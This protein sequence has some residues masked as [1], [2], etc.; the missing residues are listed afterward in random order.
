MLAIWWRCWLVERGLVEN[1]KSCVSLSWKVEV[2]ALET[3]TRRSRFQRAE[4]LLTVRTV[5]S[6]QWYWEGNSERAL[7]VALLR[8]PFDSATTREG[9]EWV[10]YGYTCPLP[11]RHGEL[12][13]LQCPSLYLNRR[14][15][16]KHQENSDVNFV[17]FLQ[18]VQWLW[19]G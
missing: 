3:G 16:Q 4:S 2:R 6:E 12:A 13:A 7:R 1:C 14:G 9:G 19:M 8:A 17:L 18:G 5:E 15:P 10:G 11:I